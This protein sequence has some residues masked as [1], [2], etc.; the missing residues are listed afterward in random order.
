MSDTPDSYHHG[1]LRTALLDAAE[2]ALF[3]EGMNKLSLRSIAKR[4]GVSHNA[5]YRHFKDKSALLRGIAQRGF[6]EL[7][8]AMDTAIAGPGSPEERLIEAGVRYVQLGLTHPDRTRLMFGGSL[9]GVAEDA[10]YRH[11][12]DRAAGVSACVIE[13]RFPIVS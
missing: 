8:A 9:E 3:T 5:P 4:A 6:E 2:D 1:N 10:V 7:H 11:A 13:F 12:A